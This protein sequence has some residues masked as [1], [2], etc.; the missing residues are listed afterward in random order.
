MI[1]Q[2]PTTSI[3]TNNEIYYLLTILILIFLLPNITHPTGVTRTSATWIDNIF[4]NTLGANVKPG[5]LTNKIISD[6]Q[7]I[8]SCFEYIISLYKPKVTQTKF[9]IN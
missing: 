9:Q 8:F 1:S 3:Y 5:I 7:I 4:A 6:H 2:N